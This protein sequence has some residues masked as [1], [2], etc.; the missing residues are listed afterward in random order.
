LIGGEIEVLGN[1]ATRGTF[2]ALVAEIDV[3]PTGLLNLPGK[4]NLGRF[5]DFMR[6]MG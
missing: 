6:G 2:L 3:F 1:G 4:R 5:L